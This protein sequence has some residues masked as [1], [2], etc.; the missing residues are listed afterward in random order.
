M[1]FSELYL[2]NSGL[3]VHFL[4]VV[5]LQRKISKLIYGRLIFLYIFIENS[6]MSLLTQCL[7]FLYIIETSMMII[8]FCNY[9]IGVILHFY[10]FSKYLYVFLLEISYKNCN[11]EV[12]CHSMSHNTYIHLFWVNFIYF[13]S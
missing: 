3:L 10:S 11:Q 9:K 6:Q 13:F 8:S 12:T 4:L 2:S 7:D 5:V 1:L